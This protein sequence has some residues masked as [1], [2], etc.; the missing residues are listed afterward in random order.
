MESESATESKVSTS[1]AKKSRTGA[2][3]GGR[4]ENQLGF[5]PD[6]ILGA[7][8]VDGVIK[9]RIKLKDSD[10]WKIADAKQAHAACPQLVID[11]YEAHLV[12]DDE[13][14]NS[15]EWNFRDLH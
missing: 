1:K 10:K 2:R 6:K 8:E 7:T 11:F 15:N 9:F 4:V 5:E 3:H 14:L 13:P 12:L